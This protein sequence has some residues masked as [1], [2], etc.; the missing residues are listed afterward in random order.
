M[1]NDIW[2]FW[3]QSFLIIV[4]TNHMARKSATNISTTH[5]GTLRFV[6]SFLNLPLHYYINGL[7]DYFLA[8]KNAHFQHLHNFTWPPPPP[9]NNTFTPKSNTSLIIAGLH[10]ESFSHFH[11]QEAEVLRIKD[12]LNLSFQD[13][14]LK[15]LAKSV[16]MK[17]R[18]ITL[19]LDP[20]R[21]SRLDWPKK[22]KI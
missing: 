3:F 8:T 18:Y 14:K 15:V 21:E 22:G 12:K 7:I 4:L 6:L 11:Q 9:N 17:L 20:E 13:L 1:S 5:P 16:K 19:E 2:V 10:P